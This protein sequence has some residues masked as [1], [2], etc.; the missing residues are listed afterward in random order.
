VLT[1]ETLTTIA[2]D[3]VLPS[4]LVIF[5]TFVPSIIEWKRPHDAGP[6]PIPGFYKTGVVTPKSILLDLDTE[7]GAP[8]IPRGFSFPVF[9][10]NLEAAVT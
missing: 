10:S 4:V 1:A 7:I 6:R 3:I 2:T 8:L 9:I 5:L